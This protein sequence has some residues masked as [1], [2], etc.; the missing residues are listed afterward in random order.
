VKSL[1][2]RE[3]MNV[4][5][6]VISLGV[7][8]HRRERTF[9]SNNGVKSLRRREDMKNGRRERNFSWGYDI[10]VGMKNWKITKGGIE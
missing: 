10:N 3:D 6:N 2:R 1:S 5:V 8:T 9:T 7:T 4:D